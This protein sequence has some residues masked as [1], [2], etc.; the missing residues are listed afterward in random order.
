MPDKSHNKNVLVNDA[1]SLILKYPSYFC[2]LYVQT[3]KNSSAFYI[4]TSACS[5]NA[6]LNKALIVAEVSSWC[7][8]L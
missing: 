3:G 4:N 5:K 7:I 8:K 6:H 2:S 1:F